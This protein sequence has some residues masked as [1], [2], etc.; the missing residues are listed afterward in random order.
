MPD[1][2]CGDMENRA[3]KVIQEALVAAEANLQELAQRHGEAAA[4]RDQLAIQ[5]AEQRGRVSAI[6]YLLGQLTPSE[7]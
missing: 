3:V 4:Q 1:V 7:V 6:R 5:V 2:P